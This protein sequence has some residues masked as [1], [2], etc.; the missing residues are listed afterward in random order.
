VVISPDSQVA[1]LT[2][3][4]ANEVAILNLATGTFGTP[5]TVG[6]EPE[7]LDI[8]PDG[9]TL[10]VA[11]SGAQ[12]ISEVDVATGEVTNTIFTPSSFDNQT[13]WQIAVGNNGTAVFTTTFNGSGFGGTAYSLNLT[14][15]M[16][17]S[18]GTV[19]ELTRVAR[20]ADY[21]TALLSLGDDSGGPVW[22]YAF[23]TG[24]KLSGT[25]SAFISYPAL[26]GNGSIAAIST[27]N[28]T[29]LMNSS[30]Q[31]TGTVSGG[32]AG[33]ALNSAGTTA[34]Q[35]ESHAVSVI[36]TSTN[37]Q[38]AS[39]PLPANATGAGQL[40]ISPDGST[41]VAI[42]TGG[43]TILST[44]PA[45]PP[46]GEGTV[47]GEVSEGGSGAAGVC[48]YLASSVS[49]Y[50]ATTASSGT[51][52]ASVPP[53][54]YD[55]LFDP[56]CDA[57]TSS[58]YALQWYADAA[59]SADATEVSI[60]SGQS[61]MAIGASLQL[62]ASLSGSVTS[63]T[64]A[65][66]AACVDVYLASNG[67]LVNFTQTQASGAYSFSNLPAANVV[68]LFDPTCDNTQASSL[69]VTFYDGA[70]TFSSATPIALAAGG[71]SSGINADLVAGASIVGTV[72]ALGAQSDGNICVYA[73]D[74]AN[75]EITDSALTSPGGA[76][77]LSNLAPYGYY[78]YVD[79]TCL[80]TQQSDYLA[81]YVGTGVATV[82]A[83]GPGQ[84]ASVNP[85]MTA[86]TPPSILT[87]SLPAGIVGSSYATSL[88][89]SGGVGPYHWSAVGLP[90]GLNI[91]TS[92]GA[93]SGTPTTGGPFNVEV[94]LTDS[95]T[96]A[97]STT[98]AV[99][100]T[101]VAGTSVTPPSTSTPP[102]TTPPPTSTPSTSTPSTNS[103]NG[104]ATVPVAATTTNKITVVLAAH[105]SHAT[106]A[107]GSTDSFALRLTPRS[108]NS[109]PTGT[110]TVSLQVKQS[111]KGK[112]HTVTKLLNR[113]KVTS[114]K[115]TVTLK[116]SGMS[117]GYQTIVIA[118]SGS[119]KYKAAS[120]SA[121]ILVKD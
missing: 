43:M 27:A 78:L 41:L 52:S 31:G 10:Y 33:V 25:M 86:A 61:L 40:A 17:T 119:S 85:L 82:Y 101:I 65:V 55:I 29:Q 13:P 16:M 108:G 3:P 35:L 63:G 87:R 118:Y 100:G 83:L 89:S 92:S 32:G 103:P 66:A 93:I 94:T 24:S 84:T 23:G 50:Q 58:A 4:A 112:A 45:T 47:R 109:S 104:T 76:F 98:T 18:L 88:S 99:A 64:S 116:T 57:T 19:T 48:V 75:T 73:V 7:G 102:S 22:R 39:I 54:T 113:T 95:S 121:R 56:T 5:I 69:A 74:P 96:P 71:N 53:G 105:A 79:P 15:D 80:S 30:L 120:T 110:I 20:S 62:G 97:F 44:N 21:S 34:Y 42:V 90:A 49:D 106:I 11:D 26:D 51:Y 1:Y 81:G 70:A 14:T 68:V 59:D 91:N 12:E 28:T 6:S 72:D 2:V 111:V 46:P 114:S 67:L 37:L 9:T 60:A 115:A 77:E 36:N 107:I 117:V 38:T 8:T